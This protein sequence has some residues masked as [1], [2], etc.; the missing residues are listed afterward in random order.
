MLLLVTMASSEG[1]SYDPGMFG[2]SASSFAANMAVKQNVNDYVQEFPLGADVIQKCFYVDD[3]LT[4]A[5]NPRSAL[6]LQ[7]QLTDLFSRGG[8]VL[9]KWNC[10]DPSVLEE[11]PKELR[12]TICIQTISEVGEYTKILGIE[13]N[14]STDEFRLSR[15][16][17]SN[18]TSIRSGVDHDHSVSTPRLDTS[19]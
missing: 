2:V 16:Q 7:R 6:S 3:C 12:D 5:D 10:S 19:C 14:V 17:R 13:W 1:L 9:R 15:C 8:F 11:I 4:G 18:M